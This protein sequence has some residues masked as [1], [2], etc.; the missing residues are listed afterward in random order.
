M[1]PNVRFLKD[2][3]DDIELLIFEW[4]E[5]H[6]PA[7][8]PLE[9]EELARVAPTNH[10]T[11]SAHLPL[12][13]GLCLPDNRAGLERAS[14]VIE[15]L[16]PLDP[17]CYIIHLDTGDEPFNGSKGIKQGLKALEILCK[18]VNAPDLICVENLEHQGMDFIDQL[19]SNS[20]ASLC[21]DIGH[22]WKAG[23]DPISWLDRW[24]DRMAVIHLHGIGKRDHES[25]ANLKPGFLGRVLKELAG[26]YSGVLTIEV[27]NEVDLRVSLDQMIET[28]RNEP[29]TLSTR[30]GPDLLERLEKALSG[31]ANPPHYP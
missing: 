4:D 1:A 21:L 14:N 30:L 26:A 17:D 5:A 7:P 24:F 8:S 31:L 12:D 28:I 2:G 13:L 6:T 11:Y 16:K 15:H 10:I 19:L 22:L 29:E 18:Q 20:A 23:Q 27:F 9:L 3:F 25:L